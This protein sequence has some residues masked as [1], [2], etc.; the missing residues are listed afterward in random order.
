MQQR[1]TTSDGSSTP[2]SKRRENDCTGSQRTGHNFGLL[3]SSDLRWRRRYNW[4]LRSGCMQTHTTCRTMT[5][6]NYW[7]APCAAQQ[8]DARMHTVRF[9][10]L[11]RCWGWHSC[12]AVLLVICG[13]TQ[14]QV[15]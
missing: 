7:W 9:L 2:M 8:S 4:R 10:G 15:P 11:G 5:G 1:A 6:C 14:K 13:E 3:R 12:S